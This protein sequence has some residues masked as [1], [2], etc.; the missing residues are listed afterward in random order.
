MTSYWFRKSHCGDKTI[1]RPS[2]L[3]NGISYTGKTTSLYWIGAL[4]TV[5]AAELRAVKVIHIPRLFDG[6]VLN[7]NKKNGI[8]IWFVQQMTNSWWK[9][10]QAILNPSVT[11]TWKVQNNY[12]DNMAADFLSLCI[13]ILQ[14]KWVMS[15]TDEERFFVTC[16]V[17]ML[18]KRDADIFLCFLKI[19]TVQQ[20]LTSQ[21]HAVL[22]KSMY[23]SKL[24]DETVVSSK[25][26]P[27]AGNLTW[28][29]Q[30]WW[31]CWA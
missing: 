29:L 25:L 13:W 16:V 3:H 5:A 4:I 17:L 22:L 10:P 27:L 9:G 19:N 20:G 12:V 1:L 30:I 31:H 2:Y 26:P 15:S 7:N 21:Y 6:Q 8:D 14:D 28:H 18:R 23:H 11:K 24:Q